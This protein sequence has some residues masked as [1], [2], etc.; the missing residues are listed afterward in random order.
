MRVPFRR[1]P[2]VFE[3]GGAFEGYARGHVKRNFWRVRELLG[4][5]EDAMQE[6]AIT[7]VQCVKRY[8]ATVDNPAWMMALYKRALAMDWAT[9]AVKDGRMRSIPIPDEAEGID[10]NYGDLASAISGGSAELQEVVRVIASAPAEF[11]GLMFSRAEA[12]HADDPAVAAEAAATLNRRIKRLLRISNPA[13]DIV[14]E[15]R[16]A[17]S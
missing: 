10:Y 17:L 7:F 3:W 2:V 9:M 11:L 4:S 12:I 8:G 13:A 15:L 16:D 6:C 14:S 1:R 5:E